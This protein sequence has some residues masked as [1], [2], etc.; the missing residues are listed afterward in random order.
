MTHAAPAFFA[1]SR[2]SC[3]SSSDV[4][5]SM[6]IASR[7][8]RDE[9]LGLLVERLANGRLRNVAVR[10]HQPA[11]RTDVADHPAFATSERFARN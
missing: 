9:S 3:S 4:C 2:P 7:A 5:V 11:E 8:C 6:M 10:L 1:A